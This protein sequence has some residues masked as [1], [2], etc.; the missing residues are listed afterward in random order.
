MKV[1]SI[2][3]SGTGSA[4]V[5]IF[6][7]FS[8]VAAIFPIF[9]IIPPFEMTVLGSLSG[10]DEISQIFKTLLLKYILYIKQDLLSLCKDTLLLWNQLKKS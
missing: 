2:S 3:E 7:R 5:W 6:G 1:V 8:I 10:S 9:E 4:S